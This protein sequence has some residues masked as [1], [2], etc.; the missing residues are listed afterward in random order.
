MLAY[1]PQLVSTMQ[2]LLSGELTY[3]KGLLIWLR[4]EKIQQVI[5]MLMI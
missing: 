4:E 5:L 1:R 2:D 3:L